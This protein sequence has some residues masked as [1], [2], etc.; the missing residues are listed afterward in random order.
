[1]PKASATRDLATAIEA[2]ERLL[3][4]LAGPNGAGKST[5]FD[6]YLAALGL[7]FVNAD[8]IARTLDPDAVA[9]LAYAG[10]A[11]A[12]LVRA[13]LVERG[14]SFCLETVFSDPV[15]AKVAFLQDAQARGYTLVLVFIGLEGPELCLG[16]VCQRVAEGG[17]DVPDDKLRKRYPRTLVNLGR[18]LEFVDHACVFD[19]SSWDQPFRLLAVVREGRVE[20]RNPPLP[21]WAGPVLGLRGTGSAGTPQGPDVPL[22]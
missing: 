11:A 5:F 2:G 21:A 7:P 15:G 20:R 1:L 12:D 19:N 22:L 6:L 16:R 10:A 4:I 13:Q 8:L 9:D 17:H 18:A 3:V 14:V